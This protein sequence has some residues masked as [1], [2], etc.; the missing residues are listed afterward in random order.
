MI[1]FLCSSC[2][3][4]KQST[5]STATS[6]V[7]PKTS[8]QT[9]ITTKV[10]YVDA[11]TKF[12]LNSD[13]YKDDDGF[14]VFGFYLI[15]MNFDNIPELAVLH[16]SGGSMGGYFQYFRFDGK[17]IVPI[18]NDDGS[19]AQCSYYTQA[20][21]DNKNKKIYLLKEMYHLQG[22]ENGTNGYVRK[23]IT[24]NG[25]PKFQN[26][27]DLEV[28][29]DIDI[30]KYD[31]TN[32]SCENDFLADTKLTNCLITKYYL[33][34]ICKNISAKEYLKLKQECLGDMN[35]YTD[36]YKCGVHYYFFDTTE[37]LFDY[38]FLDDW[39]TVPT[40]QMSRE[41]IDSLFSKWLEKNKQ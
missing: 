16:D 41:S 6:N 17:Q 20:L 27:L 23:I 12:L 34:G 11:Y 31:T 9:P 35:N 3:L 10:K 18:L 14:P 40:K 29:R 5:Q 39:S 24:K 15:D 2:S 7:S 13:N 36:L 32:D 1:I 22:N 26:V 8:S 37:Q 30:E 28:N 33:N 25:I 19:K 38:Y 21:I 4:Q